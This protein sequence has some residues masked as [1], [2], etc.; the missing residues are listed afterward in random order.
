VS[1]VKA[2]H[3]TVTG[4]EP[5]FQEGCAELLERLIAQGR[6][7]QVETNGSLSLDMVPAGARIITDVKTP[8]S[9]EEGSFLMENLGRLAPG[10][11]VKFVIADENDYRYA[12]DFIGRHLGGSAA[13]VN[14]SPAH[15]GVPPELLAGWILR[16]GIAGRINLQL[17]KIIWGEREGKILL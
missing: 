15:G 7:V 13:A 12:A 8:S 16:D 10:D 6:N 4:G 1:A 2:H 9:G 11:E 14:L 3:V 5:L 17:H